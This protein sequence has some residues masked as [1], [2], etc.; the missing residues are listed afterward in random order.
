MYFNNKNNSKLF[1]LKAFIGILF[2][3]LVSLIFKLVLVFLVPILLIIAIITSIIFYLYYKI[4]GR[5]KWFTYNKKTERKKYSQEYVKSKED[6]EKE[7]KEKE[8]L[9]R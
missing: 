9:Y 4:T 7:A 1:I 3:L 5:F 2:I 8:N 6:I